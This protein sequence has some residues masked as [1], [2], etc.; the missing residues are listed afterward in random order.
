MPLKY[1]NWRPV[2]PA[3]SANQSGWRPGP[4]SVAWFEAAVSPM[5]RDPSEPGPRRSV[6]QPVSA[7]TATTPSTSHVNT[8]KIF[9]HSLIRHKHP[10]RM[11]L[12]ERL[13]DCSSKSNGGEWLLHERQSAIEPRLAHDGIFG[14]PRH[15]YHLQRRLLHG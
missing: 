6:V 4:G 7:A 1:T 2:S 12:V 5:P 10:T 3:R 9:A 11:R 8:V 14:V 13:A 15:V